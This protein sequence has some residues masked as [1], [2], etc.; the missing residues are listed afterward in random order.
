MKTVIYKL[1]G[2]E[3]DMRYIKEC[4]SIIR[5]GGTVAF[6]T[7]T[8]YGLGANALDDEA[9]LKIYKA[10]DRPAD[11]ALL[12]HL[13]S[14]EQAEQIAY[15]TDTERMLIKKFTPGPLTVIARKKDCIGRVVTAGG[16]T[17]GLRFP[18]NR[19]ALLF[20]EETGLPLAA[21][22]A[23]ISTLPAPIDAE[24]VKGYLDGRIDAILD[25]G[26]TGSDVAST[27]ISIEDGLK[28]IR[29]G[30]ISKEEIMRALE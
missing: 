8:V 13:Y 26:K 5:S 21:T 27:I 9:C 11:K 28:I 17:V 16:T 22:S 25:C 15:L 23:N 29:E 12:C 7:E 3:E 1:N 30:A 18:S 20:M 2:T 10:K 24:T 6:P 14:I 4:A 19:E